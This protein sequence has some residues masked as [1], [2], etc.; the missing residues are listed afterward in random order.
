[1]ECDDET[2]IGKEFEC[3]CSCSVFNYEPNINNVSVLLNISYEKLTQFVQ[4]YENLTGFVP[5]VKEGTYF[6][7]NYCKLSLTSSGGYKL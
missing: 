3:I 1:M 5:I 4:T 6:F 2:V 7:K